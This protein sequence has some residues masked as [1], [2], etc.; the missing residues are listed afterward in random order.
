MQKNPCL[1]NLPLKTLRVRAYL[2][3]QKAFVDFFADTV[4][5]NFEV[6]T[7]QILYSRGYRIWIVAAFTKSL[8]PLCPHLQDKVFF[9]PNRFTQQ[10]PVERVLYTWRVHLWWIWQSLIS[11][12][13]SCVHWTRSQCLKMPQTNIWRPNLKPHLL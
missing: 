3:P 9:T 2:R 8:I 1:K 6:T 10:Y 13:P 11:I 5:T 4:Q 7:S 12:K